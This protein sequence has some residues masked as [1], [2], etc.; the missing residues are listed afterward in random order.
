MLVEKL[1]NYG[2]NEQIVRWTENWLNGQAQRV[3]V[4]SGKCSVRPVAS[5]VHQGSILGLVLIINGL[6][7]GGT[8]CTEGHPAGKQL[9]RKGPETAAARQVE[10]ERAMCPD[11]KESKWYPRLH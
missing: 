10:H 1:M 7:E 11:G 9:D 3:V 4:S 6:D 8:V 5:G 2:L